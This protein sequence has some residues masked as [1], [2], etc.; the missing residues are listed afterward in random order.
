MEMYAGRKGWDIGE[1]EVVCEYTPA[2]RGCPTRFS[3][4]LRFPASLSDEQVGEAQGHRGEVPGAPHARRRGHVRRARR[5]A[6]AGLLLSARDELGGALR[7]VLL[8]P[9]RGDRPRRPRPHRRRRPRAR[10]TS[11]TAS[12]TPS[13]PAG[14]DDMRRHAGEVAFPGGRQDDGE[15]LRTTALR[16]AEEEVGLPRADVELLGALQPVPTLAT[17]YAIYP[18]VGLIE[19]GMEWV[20]SPREVE[21]VIEP[22]LTELRAGFGRRRIVRRGIP[23]RTDVYE[24][25]RRV[26]LGRDRPDAHRPAEAA[27]RRDAARLGSPA[28]PGRRRGCPTRSTSR[29]SSSRRRGRAARA[30]RTTCARSARRCGSRR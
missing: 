1:V 19:P 8:D 12:C 10:C 21:E 15:D 18:F 16:E 3:L 14:R 2:E 28:R 17:G 4:V 29:R 9:G 13:S 11:A 24:R 23:L 20:L 7:A 26:H 25:G 5:A 22:S 27:R 6:R 30:A